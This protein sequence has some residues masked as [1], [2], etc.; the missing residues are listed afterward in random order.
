MTQIPLPA[1]ALAENHE[2]DAARDDGVR[3]IA[4]DV[5]YRQLAIVNV[6]F[7]GQPNA[8]DGSWVLIDAGVF[9]S[10]PAIRHA[11]QA[12]FGDTG[13]PACIVLTHGHFDHVGVLEALSGEWNVPVYAHP[14]EHPYLNGTRSYP[15]PDPNVGGGMLARLSPLFPTSP[16]DIGAHLRDLPPD[17]SVPFMPEFGWIHTPGH[18]PGHVSLWRERD[19]L[20]IA[21][22]AIVTTAQESV[23]ASLTQAP[24]MHG[25]PMYFTPDWTAAR[26][27]VR[28]IDALSPEIVISGHGAAM[29]GQ[30]MKQALAELAQD[31]DSVAFPEDKRHGMPPS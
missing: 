5:A 29:R 19:R 24:E 6:V 18:A 17:H 4:P 25:P 22:D 11:A 21:G 26:D 2:A 20:L 28:A 1:S 3:E 15:P 7:Y 16:V 9:G 10:G 31:F 30:E 23:Y 14:L 13:R 12:R 8:G 27:S